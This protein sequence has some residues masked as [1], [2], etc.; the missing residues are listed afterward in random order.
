MSL[1][2]IL[3]VPLVAGVVA[4][5]LALGGYLDSVLSETRET[6]NVQL[7][8]EAQV[9]AGVTANPADA[10]VVPISPAVKVDSASI[11][12]S[13]SAATNSP[14][15]VKEPPAPAADADDPAPPLRRA[16]EEYVDATQSAA[17]EQVSVAI[18]KIE[19]LPG[20]AAPS[21][22]ASESAQGD[23]ANTL[24]AQIE[25]QAKVIQQQ[26]QAQATTTSTTPVQPLD[27]SSAE[28]GCTTQQEALPGGHR[29]TVRC[30]Q[31][32]TRTGA[33]SGGSVSAVSS[34]V[35]ITTSSSVSSGGQR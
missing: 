8:T 29:T 14:S 16:I 5:S 15:A 30:I 24:R 26:A 21:A 31:Q 9:S 18:E 22:P 13:V 28:P 1:P 27:Q 2:R 25:A 35:S 23:A 33:S 17:R 12:E 20:A 4:F 19:P 7:A 3:A 32:E 34:S 6:A 10:Y 11:S